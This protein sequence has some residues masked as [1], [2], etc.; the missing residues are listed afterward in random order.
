MYELQSTIQYLQRA[1]QIIHFMSHTLTWV[2][3][4]GEWKEQVNEVIS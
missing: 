3:V 1:S 2:N 4:A